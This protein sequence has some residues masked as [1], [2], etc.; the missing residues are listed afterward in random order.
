MA[1][2]KNSFMRSKMNKDLDDRLMPNG[3]YRDAKNISIN[4]S[5]GDG[6]SE[7]NVGTA[8]T[9]LGNSLLIDFKKAIPSNPIN[10]EVIG[11]LPSDA[12]DKIF[13]FLTNN[14]I[15]PYV[16][17]GAV[18]LSYL[19][20]DNQGTTSS[21]LTLINGGSGYSGATATSSGGSGTGMTFNA[22]TVVA[23]EITAVSINNSGTGY[24][25]GDVVNIVQAGGSNAYVELTSI[26]GPLRISAAGSG[27]TAGTKTTTGGSGSGLSV[28]IEVNGSGGVTSANII[29]FGG[30]YQVGDVI[31]IS[32]GTTPATLTVFSLLQSYSAIVS[33]NP[34]LNSDFK[35]IVEGSWLNFSTLAP[36]YAIN[37]IEELLFFTDNRNQP[38]K[39]NIDNS[40]GYY[41]NEDQIS[42]AKYYPYEAIEVYQPCNIVGTTGASVNPVHEATSAVT[43]NSTTLNFTGFTNPADPTNLGIVGSLASGIVGGTGYTAGSG[44][45]TSGGTGRGLTVT[46]TVVAGVVTGVTIDNL[47][48]GY[49][50]GET[51]TILSGDNNATFVLNFILPQTFI[52]DGSNFA[53][54]NVVVNQAQTIPVGMAL[55]FVEPETTLQDA[56]DEYLSPTA[57]SVA[58]APFSTTQFDL[59]IADYQGVYDDAGANSSLVGYT[60]FKENPAGSGNFVSQNTQVTSVTKVSSTNIRIICS[61][62][63]SAP[64][65]AGDKILLGIPNPYF[66]SN[67]KNNANIDYL[68]DKFVRFSYRYRFDD[69]EYSLIAP[70]TQPCFIPEQDGYFTSNI[71]GSSNFT[72]SDVNVVSD[73]EQAYRSTEVAFMENKVNKILLN[74]PLPSTAGNLFTNFKVSEIDIL[75]KESDQTSIKVVETIPTTNNVQGS[76]NFYQYEYGSKQPFKVLPQNETTRVYDKV[77]VKALSQEVSSNRIIYG[78]YQDKHTPP[79]FL[80]YT[81]AVDIKGGSNQEFSISKNKVD[82]K[83]SIVEY[84]NATLKQNRNYEVGVVLAD[85]FGR[86]STVIFSK[87]SKFASLGE[88]L[89]S[90]IYSPYRGPNEASPT[91]GIQDF[92]GNALNIQFND[93]IRSEKDP[94]TPGIPGLYNSD[95][96]SPDYNPLGWYSFKIVVKQTE[97]EYYNVYVPTA[98]AAYPLSR[99]K[100][101]GSTSHIILT[102]DNVNKIP[103]DLS[104]VGPT[105]REF[106]S[107]V[108]LFG[109]VNTGG[110]NSAAANLNEAYFP[111]RTADLSTSVGTIQDLFNYKEF[112][113]LSTINFE[114]VFYNYEYVSDAGGSPSGTDTSFPDSSSLIARINTQSQF[115]IQVPTPSGVFTTLPALNVFET[116]PTVSL[117]DI[118]YETTTA[119]RIDLLNTAIDEGPA[120][121]Q[122]AR[123]SNFDFIGTEGNASLSDVSESFKPLRLD[124]SDFPNPAANQM[125]LISVVDGLGSST[126]AAALGTPSE[127][128]IPYCDPATPENGIFGI[129]SGATPGSFKLVLKLPGSATAVSASTSTTTTLDVGS[130]VGTIVPGSSVSGS[131]I[132]SGT[133]VVSFV[134]PTV[135]FNQNVNIG[136]LNIPLEFGADAPGLVFRNPTVAN[137]FTFTFE[138]SNP[139][140]GADAEP[141][142]LSVTKSLINV[143]PP[144]PTVVQFNPPKTDLC[145]TEQYPNIATQVGSNFRLDH[146]FVNLGRPN[147]ARVNFENGSSTSNLDLI[148]V[149]PE[150]EEIYIKVGPNF[151]PGTI[152]GWMPLADAAAFLNVS[153]D[154]NDHVFLTSEVDFLEPAGTY[155]LRGGIN[156]LEETSNSYGLPYI[157]N[158]VARD[159]GGTGS[160]CH[161]LFQILSTQTISFDNG[162]TNPLVPAC[163]GSITQSFVVGQLNGA[164]SAFNPDSQVVFNTPVSLSQNGPVEVKATLSIDNI[165][166][167]NPGNFSATVFCPGSGDYPAFQFGVPGPVGSSETQTVGIIQ[168]P[169]DVSLDITITLFANDAT[170]MTGNVGA[171]LQLS[172]C[173]PV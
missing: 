115:G 162:L 110:A 15:E 144:K 63:M 100:E 29:S 103:R 166:G 129:A 113:I 104:E 123:I 47:G 120:P 71:Q 46:I 14:I 39:V 126:N 34:I 68:K 31:T 170:L 73:E 172:Y 153:S 19:Y 61:P 150:I 143:L 164:V 70:F 121:N 157:A 55:D 44:I 114:Y 79:S 132:S 37:L 8:Q 159:A 145:Q 87:Q 97:Q 51:I 1:E 82:S 161:A 116:A 94:A 117:L 131:G 5:Q 11:L 10:L 128:A 22:I 64:F 52:V 45:L 65:A 67:F 9:V 18:G 154:P 36:I 99:E 95:Q 78:N 148:D 6:S 25:I 50:N 130:V 108:R 40:N 69:G 98:M 83:T 38:R 135:T 112:P 24:Q 106:P 122:F 151:T 12:E 136:A 91:N 7:G 17:E 32:G 142:L 60:V 169:I 88:F 160:I 107:S 75:Y 56:V 23:G 26:Q 13:A 76:S 137:D 119:G 125:T 57:T 58:A 102:N 41:F 20:P 28:A 101:L 33:Y 118:Y 156:F 84:P 27:Y 80:D 49:T 4:K 30:G 140:A 96:T 86:Q 165:S 141:S 59:L 133:K 77:P 35:I 138:C 173:V 3:E 53:A 109:R 16:P 81:L 74:I 48:N 134:S 167:V 171:T 2:V 152:F 21:T 92:D 93:L 66:D 146:N 72:G 139:G 127:T 155:Y 111:S 158:I 89:A 43:T 147:I 149:I 105:Q 54:G 42:V 124:G 163:P 62:A 168:G 85:R 90:S